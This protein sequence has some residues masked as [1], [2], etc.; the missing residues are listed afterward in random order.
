MRWGADTTQEMG[1]KNVKTTARD[2][3][4]KRGLKERESSIVKNEDKNSEAESSVPAEAHQMPRLPLRRKTQTSFFAPV[5]K[6][7]CFLG[8]VIE[9][10][11]D[12]PFFPM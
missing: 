6:M 4:L 11:R 5:R 10:F 12:H 1:A 2:Q 7:R 3:Q 8:K 9:A